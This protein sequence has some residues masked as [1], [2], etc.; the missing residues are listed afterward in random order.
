MKTCNSVILAFCAAAFAVALAPAQ[1]VVRGTA[2]SDDSTA[3]SE[4]TVNTPDRT[5]V[6]LVVD[7]QRSKPDAN[8]ERT[9][10]VT[11]ARL[12][13][14]T[15]YDW[16]RT[17][18]VEKRSPDVKQISNE[19]IEND[20]Q[21]GDRVI[22]TTTTTVAGSDQ[23]EQ[24]QAKVY[25]RNSSGQ[26]VLDRIMDANIVS[27]GQGRA[28]TVRTDG[29]ADVNGNVVVQQQNDESSVEKS[30]NE[31]VTTAV[32]KSIDHLSGQ[33]DV[34]GEATTTEHTENG[35]KQI[36]TVVRAPGRLGWEPTRETSTIEKTAPDGTRIRETV[37][38]GRSLYSVQ[39]GNQ[40]LEPL[41]P[42]RKVIE[43]EVRTANGEVAVEREVFHR[44]VNGDWQRESFSTD[45]PDTK[46]GE[47][48]PKPAG[49]QTVAPP[50]EAAP[51]AGEVH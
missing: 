18:T 13:D 43:R 10:A 37:E 14:G 6:P 47:P 26:L 17:S 45:Q 51:P 30:P 38:K 11:R 28:N 4:V 40:L 19:V 41:E 46:I 39:T 5:V 15:Y 16:R 3:H 2:S 1:V 24:S 22:R 25:T 36:D 50:P 27:N 8:T 48:T 29:V 20:R 34:T 35:V 49:N 44:N 42:Q 31:K 32:T 33:V 21:G 12:N 9:D 7:V 23:G